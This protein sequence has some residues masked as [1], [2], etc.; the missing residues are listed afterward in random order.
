MLVGHS[1][2]AAVVLMAALRIRDEGGA[3][4]LRGLVLV[5]G[6]VYEQRFPLFMRLAQIR[7]LGEL[8]LLAPPPRWI[9][10]FGIRR[11]ARVRACVDRELVE[12]YRAPLSSFRRRRAVL[13][14]VRQIRP[15]EAGQISPRYP[16]VT[17]PTLVLAGEEDP[18]V[19]KALV[20]RLAEALPRGR[21]VVLPGIGHLVPEEAPEAS[22]AA[23]RAFLSDLPEGPPA[24]GP[25]VSPS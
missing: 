8:F 14:A 9:M 2:G 19:P 6:A 12:G 18:V 7:P 21:K 23:L 24:V 13:R 16:E 4:P 22:L 15:A 25:P 3:I 5:N 1:L 17:L 11:V 10:R 20:D